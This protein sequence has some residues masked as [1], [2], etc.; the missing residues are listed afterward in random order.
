LAMVPA[1]MR[2]PTSLFGCCLALL[3]CGG[4]TEDS[5]PSDAQASGDCA[6]LEKRIAES[7]DIAKVCDPSLDEPSCDRIVEGRCCAEVVNPDNAAAIADYESALAK[8]RAL[9]CFTELCKTVKCASPKTGDCRVLPVGTSGACE[10][11]F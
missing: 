2:F 1:E 5:V 8:A 6:T 9:G 10:P 7:L 11:V 3:A 4:T